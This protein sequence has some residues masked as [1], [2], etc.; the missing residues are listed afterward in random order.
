MMIIE[1]LNGGLNDEESE[2]E[3]V[4]GEYQEGG[5][6][7]VSELCKVM[8]SRQCWFL[9]NGCLYF[10]NLQLFMLQVLVWLME[11]CGVCCICY[12]NWIDE[13]DGYMM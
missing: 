1:G 2:V 5:G 9:Q 6:D 3:I 7:V 4:M 11:G 12:C 8:E 13:S 10:G